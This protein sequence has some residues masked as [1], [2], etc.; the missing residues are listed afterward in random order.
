MT[1]QVRA[2]IKTILTL[3][4]GAVIGTVFSVFP[5]VAVLWSVPILLIIILYNLFLSIED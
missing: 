2:I 5:Q 1:K 3:L 4:L